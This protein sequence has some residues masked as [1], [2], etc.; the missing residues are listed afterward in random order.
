MDLFKDQTNESSGRQ[1][2][3]IFET[4][5]HQ[6]SVHGNISEKQNDCFESDVPDVTP[7]ISNSSTSNHSKET[8]NEEVDEVKW[9]KKQLEEANKKLDLAN[10]IILKNN[11]C[12]TQLKKHIKRLT[13][14]QDNS[15]ARNYLNLESSMK[16]LFNDD[17]IK[18]LTRKSSRGCLC[19][20]DTIKKALRLKF[21]CGS[22]GYQELRKQKMYLPSERTLRRKLESIQF[23]EGICD[24]IFKLLEDK[25]ALFQDVRE[26]DCVLILD[27]MAIAPG[28]QFDSSTQ[29]YCGIASF[30][31]RNDESAQATHGLIFVLAGIFS[32]WKQ[33]V[34]FY[35][36]PDSYDGALLHPIVLEIIQKAEFIGLYVHGVTN[37]MGPNN[38][39]MW[40]KFLVGF[41]GRYST[42]EGEEKKTEDEVEDAGEE[43]EGK[44]KKRESAARKEED[45]GK[46]EEVGGSVGGR[47]ERAAA[48][49]KIEGTRA[50]DIAKESEEEGEVKEGGKRR[51]GKRTEGAVGGVRTEGRN[52]VKNVRGALTEGR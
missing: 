48:C 4:L 24:D 25:V 18:V 13:T 51:R 9:L 17:Q 43:K 20:N 12:N 34:A 6:T 31:T 2:D 39:A 29:S 50:E 52:E 15:K 27:E 1:P 49:G 22:S 16:L 10:K 41:A 36:T 45:E 14:M 35:L 11:R 7:S 8:C 26:K 3:V 46:K 44:E 33:N 38:L 30:C 42:S 21:S 40:R 47:R 37:D 23:E 5:D 28:Q 32:R 19:S